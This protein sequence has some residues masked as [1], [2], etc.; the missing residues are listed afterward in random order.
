MIVELEEIE[1][2]LRLERSANSSVIYATIFHIKGNQLQ[3]FNIHV[4]FFSQWSGNGLIS[5]YLTL[6]LDSIGY[7]QTLKNGILNISNIVTTMIFS[8]SISQ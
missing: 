7:K 8:P 3:F 4:R 1:E 5:Y 6:V 2:A